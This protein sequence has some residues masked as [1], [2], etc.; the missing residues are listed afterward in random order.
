MQFDEL[1]DPAL[2]ER[3]KGCKSA[4]ELV[5]L[6]EAEGYELDDSQLESISGG[7]TW[8]CWSH[9]CGGYCPDLCNQFR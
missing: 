6:I 1:K 8:S 2:Q 4:A 9:D 3:L 7:S 5:E